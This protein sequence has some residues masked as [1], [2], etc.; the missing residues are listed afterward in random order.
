MDHPGWYPTRQ[1]ELLL[2]AALL[3]GDSARESWKEWRSAID[4]DLIDLGSQR[5][6][7][8]LYRNLNRLEIEDPSADTRTKAFTSWPGI[9]IRCCSAKSPLS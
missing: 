2:R 9:R 7:P 1:Q 8:L 6:L 4:I 5:L 3:D